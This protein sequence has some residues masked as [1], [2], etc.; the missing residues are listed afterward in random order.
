MAKSCYLGTG[1]QMG[2]A[3]G[4]GT[5]SAYMQLGAG[6]GAAPA[7]GG[8]VGQAYGGYSMLP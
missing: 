1:S 8:G 6:S 5:N 2:A 4:G 7:P 3:P